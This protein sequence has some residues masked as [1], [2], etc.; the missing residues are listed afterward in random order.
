MRI[1]QILTLG[2]NCRMFWAVCTLVLAEHGPLLY[3]A[4]QSTIISE[5]S[6]RLTGG[7]ILGLLR[8]VQIYINTN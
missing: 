5:T 2:I 3:I 8:I 7:L 1:H 4:L 6:H